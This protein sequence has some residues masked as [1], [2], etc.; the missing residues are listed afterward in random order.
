HLQWSLE[1]VHC[2]ITDSINM[3]CPCCGIHNCWREL[4]TPQD[5][6][7]VGHQS[8]ELF[9]VVDGCSVPHVL[10]CRTCEPHVS[11]EEHFLATSQATFM[12]HAR[13]Q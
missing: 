2:I 6:W 9:C 4:W 7:C 5:H 3:G 13:L 1:Y 11:V 12:L 8:W 10:G